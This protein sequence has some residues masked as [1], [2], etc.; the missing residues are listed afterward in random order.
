MEALVAAQEFGVNLREF[1]QTLPKPMVSL[2]AVP[3][4]LPLGWGFEQEFKHTARDQTDRQIIERAVPA[5][6]SAGAIGFAAGG[7]ALGE[8]G[9]QE[10]GRNAQ[11]TQERNFAL[12]QRQGRGA[13]EAVYLSQYVG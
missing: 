3:A 5:P 1:L 13:A 12:A 8:G 4:L 2:D 6:L 9:A 11:L 10:L 7:E